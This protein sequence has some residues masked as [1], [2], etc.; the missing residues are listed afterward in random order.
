MEYQWAE[1]RMAD[2]NLWVSGTGASIRTR[3]SLDSRLAPQP[4]ASEVIANIL[5]VL[6]SI[7]D[8]CRELGECEPFFV[9]Q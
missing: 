7:V 8:E 2:F 4:E 6:S 1:N 5:L 3:A 9:N